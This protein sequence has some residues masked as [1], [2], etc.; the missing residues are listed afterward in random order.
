MAIGNTMV[1][2]K[3]VCECV[4]VCVCVCVNGLIDFNPTSIVLSSRVS[5]VV[6][7]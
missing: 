3:D 7:T 4:F 2:V 5:E 1:I 6:R